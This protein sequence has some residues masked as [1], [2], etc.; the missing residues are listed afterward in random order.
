MGGGGAE[1]FSPFTVCGTDDVSACVGEEAF[2]ASSA[3]T[4]DDEPA[5]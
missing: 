5:K 3:F 2:I 4:S 1:E